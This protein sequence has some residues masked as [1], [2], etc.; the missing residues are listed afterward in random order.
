VLG[1]PRV[2]QAC[3]DIPCGGFLPVDQGVH[4]ETRSFARLGAHIVQD[5]G[6]TA[7]EVREHLRTP[8]TDLRCVGADLSVG[9]PWPVLFTCHRAVQGR[10]VVA[11]RLLV[12]LELG[13]GDLVG[14]VAAGE[15]GD[16]LQDPFTHGAVV[17]R[18]GRRRVHGACAVGPDARDGGVVLDPAGDQCVDLEVDES[19]LV[20]G[21]CCRLGDGTGE[22]VAAWFRR[23]VRVGVPVERGPLDPPGREGDGV[24]VCLLQ[25]LLHGVPVLVRVGD[26]LEAKADGVLDRCLDERP[27][28]GRG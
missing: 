25:V 20:V 7:E 8:G 28:D 2:A 4:S 21:P 24:D 26:V 12:E 15:L 16:E 27:V 6:S 10:V 23:D 19:R 14:L 17:Q 1:E 13:E 9:V 18:A 11:E 3:I 22:M 5:G